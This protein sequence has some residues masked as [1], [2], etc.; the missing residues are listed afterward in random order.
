MKRGNDKIALN[1]RTWQLV[2]F[3]CCNDGYLYG[4]DKDGK[5]RYIG[6]KDRFITGI[7]NINKILKK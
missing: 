6:P 1:L 5:D 2:R 4:F 7:A 3:N